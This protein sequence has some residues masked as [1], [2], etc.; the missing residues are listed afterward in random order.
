M[1]VREGCAGGCSGA[2]PNV[3]VAIYAMPAPGERADDVAI[4][5][6]TYVYSL[7]ALDCLARVIDDSLDGPRASRPRPPAR[8]G[9]PPRP[10]AC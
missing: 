9:R 7:P 3:A 4:A 5:W 2:G 10:P 6:K 8:S 1:S